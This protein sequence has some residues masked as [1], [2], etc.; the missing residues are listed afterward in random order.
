MQIYKKLLIIP[1]FFLAF[2]AFSPSAYAVTPSLSISPTSSYGSDNVTLNINGDTNSSVY[3]YYYSGSTWQSRSLGVTG[4]NGYLSVTVSGSTYGITAGNSV[5]VLVNGQQSPSVVWPYNTSSYYGSLSLSQTSVTLAS[6]QSTTVSVYNPNSYYYNNGT[7]YVSGNSNPSVVTASVSGNTVYLYGVGYGSST[8]TICLTGS[9]SVCGTLYVTVNISS[10][11]NN[12]YVYPYNNCC[13][14]ILNN[15]GLNITSLSLPLRGSITVNSNNATGLYVSN[16]SNPSVVS[17]TYNTAIPQYYPYSGSSSV[18]GC[19]AGYQYS[20][21]TG[22]P[23]YNYG[24]NN[25]NYYPNS[26]NG[27]SITISG[28]TVGTSMITLC[29]NSSTNNCSAIYV[30]VGY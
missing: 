22:Q 1:L 28:K 23:C 27:V 5:Y 14:N 9:S 24:Y 7:F 4:N 29:A 3:L 2:L 13:G 8:V 21:I 30:T 6:G 18:P 15:L 25:Y 26:S 10:Y 11:N 17:A 16:N 20:V 19:Y 12:P